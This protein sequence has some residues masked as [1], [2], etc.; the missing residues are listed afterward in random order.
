MG[1]TEA[2]KAN[3]ALLGDWHGQGSARRQRPGTLSVSWAE[4]P[5][6]SQNAMECDLGRKNAS[7]GEEQG[8]LRQAPT[9]TVKSQALG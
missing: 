6:R 5:S 2:P 8:V 7:G 4:L 1:H 9:L 3:T